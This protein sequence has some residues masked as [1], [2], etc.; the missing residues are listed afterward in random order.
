MGKL[1]TIKTQATTE[2]V[3]DFIAKI[4]NDQK[5]QDTEVMVKLME[6]LAKEKPK[7]WGTAIIG[8]GE[9]RYKSPNTDREVDWFKIGFSPRKANLSLYF[10]FNHQGQSAKL[11]KLGKHKIGGGCIYINKLADIDLKVLAEII[12]DA[13]TLKG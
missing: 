1:A 5:R 2:S 11:K 12:T 8:F 9:L 6:K 10:P 4:P 7:L 13:L 3:Q